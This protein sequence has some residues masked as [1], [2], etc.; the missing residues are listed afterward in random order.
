MLWK[1]PTKFHQHLG[2]IQENSSQALEKSNEKSA[3][4][5]SSKNGK[6]NPLEIQIFFTESVNKIKLV[7]SLGLIPWKFFWEE[8]EFF[9]MGLSFP[10]ILGGKKSWNPTKIQDKNSGIP[11]FQGGWS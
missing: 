8:G 9:R 2:K 4:I 10:R 7:C 3:W 11:S 5:L 1:N 6:K